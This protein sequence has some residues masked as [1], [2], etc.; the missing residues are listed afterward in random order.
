MAWDDFQTFLAVAK[1]G[2]HARAGRALG[3]NPTTIGRR[4]AALE[5]RVGA[6]L[7]QRTPS[8]L[9]LTDAGRSV[10]PRAER[11]DLEILALERELGGADARLAGSVRLTAGDA[12]TSYVLLP[13]LAILQ[14]QHPNLRLELRAD[15]RNLDLS[16]RD[17]DVAVRLSRPK[18]PALA[19]RKLGDMPFALFAGARY[20]E[21][22]GAPR[23]LA[24][25]VDHDFIALDVGVQTPQS[26][27]LARHAP[28]VEARLVV[29]TT[30]AQV[31]ACESGHGLALMPRFLAPAHA[32]LTQLLPRAVVPAREIWGVA[33]RDTQKNARVRAVM[34]WLDGLFERSSPKPR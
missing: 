2:S 33:H 3:V 12:V 22:R 28:Q 6:Q 32:E 34:T 24:Q 26:R 27:F 14:R 20:L 23:S 25:L 21:R 1:T 31:A 13:A 8:G 4:L 7:F 15:T 19:A 29:N 11:V 10:L 17:A 30:M 9:L 5:A 16:R 18:E